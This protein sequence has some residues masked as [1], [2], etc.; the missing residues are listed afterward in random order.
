[1]VK[2]AR[3]PTLGEGHRGTSQKKFCRRRAEYPFGERGFKHRTQRVRVVKTVFLQNGFFVPYQKQVVLTK[4][5]END[6]LHSTHKNKGCAPQSPETDKNDENGGCPSD[7]TTV[8]KK[9]RFRHPEEL[10]FPHRVPGRELSEFLSAYHLCDNAYSL[11]FSQ[12]SPSLPQNSVRLS[13]FSS[14]KHY[15]RNSIPPVSYFAPS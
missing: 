1:M 4:N 6:D 10:F 3:V 14:P 7:K 13:E 8:C 12:K 2:R 5:G 9:H 11:S 15:S